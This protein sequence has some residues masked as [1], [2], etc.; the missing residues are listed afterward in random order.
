M[1]MHYTLDD[2]IFTEKFENCQLDPTWFTH[3]AHLRLGY[4]YIR[5]WGIGLASDKLCEGIARFDRVF[6]SGTKFH[7]TITKA[8]AGIIGH[9]M[10]KAK[11]T[12]FRTFIHEFP[13]LKYEFKRLLFTHYSSRLLD[14]TF[15][16]THY[17]KPDLLPDLI[18]EEME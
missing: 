14:T 13:Q 8:S 2:Q 10:R 15:S 12:D 16:R 18:F 3:E 5:R 17:Q 7:K 9:F 4:L 11:A 1:E 6:G